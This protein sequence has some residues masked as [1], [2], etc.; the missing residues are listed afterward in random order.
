MRTPP[1][2][3]QCRGN[4]TTLAGAQQTDA[5]I[6]LRASTRV[7]ALRALLPLVNERGRIRMAR[8]D[9]EVRLR[10]EITPQPATTEPSL[11]ELFKQ[12][13]SDTTELIRAEMTLAK[14]EMREVG[15]TL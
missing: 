7:C 1:Y 8:E 10:G 2:V 12:L 3:G 14:V 13:T 5:A 6:S 11:G 4:D 9:R 15:T